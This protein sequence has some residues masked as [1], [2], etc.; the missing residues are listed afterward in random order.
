M[1]GGLNPPDFRAW[2]DRSGTCSITAAGSTSALSEGSFG[3]FEEWD[4]IK[5]LHAVGW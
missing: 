3:L 5:A 1:P 2:F 4:R